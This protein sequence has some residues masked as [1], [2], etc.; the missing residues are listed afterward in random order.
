MTIDDRHTIWATD[1]KYLI[2]KHKIFIMEN[3][4]FKDIDRNARNEVFKQNKSN[5]RFS[6][7]VMSPLINTEARDKIRRQRQDLFD[8]WENP[9]K[10]FLIT[11]PD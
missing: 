1:Q 5:L 4:S 2:Q 11:K 10:S 9:G 8:K 3:Q 6:I 7:E